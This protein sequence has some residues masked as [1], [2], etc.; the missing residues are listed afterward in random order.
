MPVTINGTTGIAGVDGSAATPAVQGTDTNTGIFFPAADTIAF[1]EGGVEAM[2]IDSSGNVGIGTSSPGY[3]LDVQDSSSGAFSVNFQNT[4]SG[5]S[6]QARATFTSTSNT[7]IVGSTNNTGLGGGG[8]IYNGSVVP[9]TFFTS[10]TERMRIDSSGRVTTP[11]QPFFSAYR[12]SDAVYSGGA[13]VIWNA[14]LYNVGSHYSTSTGRF[15][16]PVAGV[17]LLRTDFRQDGNGS[18]YLDIVHSNGTRTRH[19]EGN[20]LNG[21][22][23]TLAAI[24]YMNAGDYVY[25]QQGGATSIRPD[26]GS[27]TDRFEGVLLG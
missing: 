22:H 2:R 12:S 13:T 26:G 27:T 17:Y 25:T 23:Q 14:T 21:F 1:G 19:E 20:A 4:N 6:A 11:Y 18:G 10:A 24:Y 5:S 7:L 15:T 8:F 3:K 9:L 16:A